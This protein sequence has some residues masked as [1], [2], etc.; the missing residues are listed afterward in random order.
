MDI[1]PI[2]VMGRSLGA[3]EI[4]QVSVLGRAYTD[5]ANADA[6]FRDEMTER[7]QASMDAAKRVMVSTLDRIYA[8]VRKEHGDPWPTG[9]GPWGTSPTKL[10]K[11]SGRGLRSIGASRKVEMGPAFSVVTGQIGTGKMT[12]HETGGRVTARGRYLTIPFK[13]ALDGKGLPL[14]RRARDWD[15][16]F[17][18]R[19]RRGNL[20]I[21][22][23]DG[24]GRV[25]PL[26]LLKKSVRIPARLGLAET[27]EQNVPYFVARA[28]RT[29]E[30]ELIGKEALA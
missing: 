8:A 20:I 7:V 17:V 27:V 5:L 16:T 12:I 19:S 11:R 6:V 29:I 21:F 15:N 4:T 26:Y 28:L 18:Q 25:V 23:K 3:L 30:K 13:S 24:S 2:T 10:A 22:R 1:G 14:K 9:S